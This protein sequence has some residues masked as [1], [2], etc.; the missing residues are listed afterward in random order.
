MTKPEALPP[1]AAQWLQYCLGRNLGLFAALKQG[2]AMPLV[3][4]LDEEVEAAIAFYFFE[5]QHDEDFAR[6]WLAVKT[7]STV[8]N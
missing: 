6:A 2:H 3:P 5:P 7:G 8:D 1:A 4:E